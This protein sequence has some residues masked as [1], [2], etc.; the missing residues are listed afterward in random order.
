L[1]T[2]TETGQGIVVE[3]RDVRTGKRIRGFGEFA[4]CANCL[5]FSADGAM[6]AVGDD[7]G[8]NQELNSL[9]H[10]HEVASGKELRQISANSGKVVSL[11]FSPDGRTVAAWH[12]DNGQNKSVLILWEVASGKERARLTELGTHFEF[13]PLAFSGDGRALASRGPNNTIRL[14]DYA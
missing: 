3:L 5:S 13:A 11:E 1:A 8:D 9:I 12:S 14:W 2:E 7:R 6:L 10:I 4:R